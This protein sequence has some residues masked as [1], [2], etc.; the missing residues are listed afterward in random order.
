MHLFKASYFSNNF[1]T[2]SLEYY[3]DKS[4]YTAVTYL[5]KNLISVLPFI[6]LFLLKQLSYFTDNILNGQTFLVIFFNISVHFLYYLCGSFYLCLTLINLL[7][8]VFTYQLIFIASVA[9]KL[10][11]LLLERLVIVFHEAMHLRITCDILESF[12]VIC[13]LII[14]QSKASLIR[15]YWLLLISNLKLNIIKSIWLLIHLSLDFLNMNRQL[16]VFYLK[17]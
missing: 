5:C 9:L 10:L 6:D 14:V 1:V 4:I 17:L 15:I 11:L 12:W 13:P 16:L 2:L 3:E 8:K 7:F